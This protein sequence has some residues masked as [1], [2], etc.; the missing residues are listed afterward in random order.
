M[1][2]QSGSYRARLSRNVSWSPIFRTSSDTM[3]NRTMSHETQVAFFFPFY[4]PPVERDGNGTILIVSDA[5]D[6]N[7]LS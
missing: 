5:R 2:L 7:V 3:V 1:V 4:F 6:D